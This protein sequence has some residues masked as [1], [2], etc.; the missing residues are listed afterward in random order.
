MCGSILFLDKIWNNIQ[1]NKLHQNNK[2][3]QDIPK[4]HFFKP[5]ELERSLKDETVQWWVGSRGHYPVSCW[6]LS[7]HGGHERWTEKDCL[8]SRK[9]VPGKHQTTFWNTLSNLQQEQHFHIWSKKIMGWLNTSIHKV[10]RSWVG[11]DK[12]KSSYNLSL[13]ISKYQNINVYLTGLCYY[14]LTDSQFQNSPKVRFR[15]VKVQHSQ[16]Q[17][18]RQQEY[19]IILLFL[20]SL[21]YL[22][23]SHSYFLSTIWPFVTSHSCEFYIELNNHF[24]SLSFADFSFISR[25]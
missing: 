2:K 6:S 13:T 9:Q 24:Y 4:V 1:Y 17:F 23:K 3:S 15:I 10:I 25:S 20:T 8:C 5:S 19:L 11:Q 16:G 21:S 18:S 7:R 12:R 14:S 22:L